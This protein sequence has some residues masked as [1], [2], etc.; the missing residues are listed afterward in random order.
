MVELKEGVLREKLSACFETLS[1]ETRDSLEGLERDALLYLEVEEVDLVA[2]PITDVKPEELVALLSNHDLI[3][4][5]FRTADLLLNLAPHVFP[6]SLNVV[7][8]FL[9]GNLRLAQPSVLVDRHL[10][11]PLPLEHQLLVRPLILCLRARNKGLVH[12]VLVL[13]EGE[14]L[15]GG[16]IA[17]LELSILLPLLVSYLLYVVLVP[18]V[19][20]LRLLVLPLVGS[21]LWAEFFVNLS[22]LERLEYV[23]DVVAAVGARGGARLRLLDD[24]RP[25]FE[26]EALEGLPRVALPFDYISA[27]SRSFTLGRVVLASIT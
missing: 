8:G 19:D 23:I 17:N 20:H 13:Q 5:D 1:V 18:V 4:V 2:P 14:V 11:V 24:Q 12:H 15:S 7:L 26:V 25:L 16:R 6:L 27:R 21:A 9:D 10:E 22:F 3:R